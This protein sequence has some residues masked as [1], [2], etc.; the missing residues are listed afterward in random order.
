MSRHDEDHED[1]VWR[2]LGTLPAA[3]P[4]R[5]LWPMVRGRLKSRISFRFRLLIAATS[6]AAAAAGLAVGFL[7]GPSAGSTAVSWQEE[8]W[9]AVG[10]L[11]ADGSAI[12]FDDVYFSTA[13][14]EGGDER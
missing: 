12:T 9:A 10:S 3:E 14:D 11:V 1:V 8:T 7:M 5:P 2:A 4:P 6:S 13:S